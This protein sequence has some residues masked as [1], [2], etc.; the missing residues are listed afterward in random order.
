MT[1]KAM[2]QSDFV[3]RRKHQRHT[4]RDDVKVVDQMTGQVL[5]TIANLSEEGIMLVHNAPLSTENIYQI[6]L[7]IDQGVLGDDPVAIEMGIDCLWVSPAGNTASTYWSGCQIIDM[8]D[9]AYSRIMDVIQ[10]LAE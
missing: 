9:D 3:S 5:G 6:R 7:E 8:S 10:K 4:L 2:E 1:G